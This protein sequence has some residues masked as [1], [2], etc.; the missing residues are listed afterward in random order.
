[1]FAVLTPD[2]RADTFPLF[3]MG[4]EPLRSGGLAAEADIN[5]GPIALAMRPD[6]VVAFASGARVYWIENGR[7]RR[8]PAPTIGGI[9]A[10]IAFAPDGTLL[11]AS[12]D[13]QTQALVL[14]T[15]PGTKPAV[16][17]GTRGRRGD[18]GDGGPATAARLRCPSSI[19]VDAT[20]GVLIA[21]IEA[22][23]IRRVDPQGI[24][25]T[26]AGNGR[27]RF[28]GDGGPATSAAIGYAR[29]VA[30]LPGG[31]FAI[32]TTEAHLSIPGDDAI[33]VVDPAGVI[34]TRALTYATDVSATRDGS[35]LLSDLFTD[36]APVRRLAPDGTISVVANARRDRV[37]I[38]EFPPA[39]GDPFASDA[40]ITDAALETPDGGMLLAADFGISYVP[41]S[42][43]QL[44]A[45]AILPR[46]RRVGRELDVSIRLT[47]A[48]RVT[49][50]ARRGGRVR[51]STALDVPAGDASVP[52]GRLRAGLHDVRVVAEAEGQLA[53]THAFVF[54]GGR[55]P[56]AWARGFVSAR[57][58]LAET[59]FGGAP[60][61]ARCLRRSAL[62]VDCGLRRQRRCIGSLSVRLRRD[63]SLAERAHRG[64]HR[65]RP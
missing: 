7:L 24:I 64:R 53:V 55:L 47:H 44:L 52:L 9:S 59:F 65:C 17:A 30:A 25:R 5:E 40:V 23:R 11:V 36:N 19:D 48:A 2:A 37:G 31:G 14:R 32:A 1:V 6:G 51:A 49:V 43:P 21:D 46:T 50:Q 27:R 18:S 33:R 38:P 22:R 42:A 62:R 4:T 13:G 58:G 20:G 10:D 57:L 28:S 29:S 12:C 8:V 60:K 39:A 35:L 63:G 15:A 16:V 45:A 56:V 26:V 61:L 54:A 34:S 41:P 3:G